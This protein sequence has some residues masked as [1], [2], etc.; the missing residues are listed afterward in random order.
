MRLAFTG[1]AGAG[2]TYSALAVATALV[3][4]G[5]VAL[6]DT[7]HGS[8]AKYADIFTFDTAVLEPPFHPDRYAEAIADAPRAGYD[9]LILDSMSHA[10]TGEGGMLD[11]VNKI[12]RASYQGNTF[13]AWKD[14]TPIQNRLI[15]AIL[16]ANIHIIATMRS[17][18]EYALTK[19]EKTGKSKPEKVGT[20]PIQRDG[21]EYEYDIIIDLGIDNV[22]VVNKTRCPAL[23]GEVIQKPGAA[24][25]ATLRDWLHGAPPP[26]V[27]G[28]TGAILALPN[29]N[30]AFTGTA[31]AAKFIAALTADATRDDNRILEAADR[32][33]QARA[34][35][36]AGKD[37]AAAAVVW[38]KNPSAAIA[39]PAALPVA[40]VAPNAGQDD[41]FG[42]EY[43][44][45]QAALAAARQG[46]TERGA[47]EPAS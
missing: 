46:G 42:A 14:G 11:I 3:P 34:D 15:E 30:L 21:F 20:A 26:P 41:L 18:T 8:A 4:G 29:S 40:K 17:K 39:F 7:E 24:L 6:L 1:P 5:R 28:L 10:W 32:L 35:G 12:A 31:G 38:Y 37:A 25:A 43:E 33:I 2:K 45:R 36:L 44:Q 23:T 19:D 16:K 27:D 9:V 22:G 13:A 47:Q